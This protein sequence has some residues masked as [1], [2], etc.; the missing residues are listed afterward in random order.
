MAKSSKSEIPEEPEME[1]AGGVLWERL[2]ESLRNPACPHCYENDA[3]LVRLHE[4]PSEW[5][6]VWRC[7]NCDA[8]FV[9]PTEYDTESH[10][11]G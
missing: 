6:V 1:M 9:I 10:T 7:R 2:G 8:A 4:E 11:M 5:S 3:S